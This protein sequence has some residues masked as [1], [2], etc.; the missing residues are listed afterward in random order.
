MVLI[1]NFLTY[2]SDKPSGFPAP[3]YNQ[4]RVAILRSRIFQ[5]IA[6]EADYQ[7]LR[8][9]MRTLDSREKAIL[10]GRLAHS[11]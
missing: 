9:R 8:D 5:K 1:I 10:E 11:N 6:T 3:G 7:E 4:E 2:M